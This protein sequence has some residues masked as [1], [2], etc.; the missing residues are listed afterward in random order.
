MKLETLGEHV[1]NATVFKGPDEKPFLAPRGVLLN[2]AV[3]AVCDTGQNRVLI[4]KNPDQGF[5]RNPDLILGQLD[6]VT[7][8]RNQGDSA[9]ASTL[10]YPTDV[11]CDGKKIIIADA[12]NHRVLIWNQFPRTNGAEADIVIGQPNFNN[13]QPNVEGMG[14]SPTSKSLNW[15]YGIYCDG[16]RLWVA[17]TGNRRVLVYNT[18][19]KNS[20]SAADYVIGKPSFNERDYESEDPIWPYSIKLSEKGELL[21]SDTQFFRV[22]YWSNWKNALEKKAEI[23]F[24]QED[25]SKSGQNQ[26][27]LQPNKRCLNWVYDS[28]F[29]K[30][31]VLINDTGN[32]RLLFFDHIPKNNNPEATLVIGRPDFNTSSEYSQTLMGTE[33]AIYWPFSIRIIGSKLVIAESSN[34]RIILTD[35]K[36]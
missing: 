25:L 32:S 2:N 28:C 27:L 23:V 16:E 19:P 12:W 20:Y 24:G 30:N 26:F 7:T 3:F 29:Y 33:K 36:F 1:A 11:W 21:I 14:K 8:S 22:L 15:P 6:G 17:D 13:N 9:S 35:L 5:N 34:H 4:W 31:G 18:I 10:L